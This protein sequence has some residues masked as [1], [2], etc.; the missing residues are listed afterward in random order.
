VSWIASR[1][2]GLLDS[3]GCRSGSCWPT[4]QP[5]TADR[6][7]AVT[8]K[9]YQKK[10]NSDNIADCGI[11][12]VPGRL[13][14]SRNFASSIAIGQPDRIDLIAHTN[15]SLPRVPGEAD[16]SRTVTRQYCF[17]RSPAA[18]SSIEGMSSAALQTISSVCTFPSRCFLSF[19][20]PPVN[21]L[22]ASVMRSRIP[23]DLTSD[24]SRGRHG[25]LTHT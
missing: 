17:P 11:T 8:N 15:L 9:I 23:P 18:P 25:F 3:A 16:G 12:F 21:F 1:S 13:L 22:R 2:P 5:T 14:T 24:P 10:N 19:L 20:L 4:Q 7:F 6:S